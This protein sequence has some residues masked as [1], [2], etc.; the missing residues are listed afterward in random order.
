MK[1]VDSAAKRLADGSPFGPSPHR[2]QDAVGY[3]AA[4]ANPCSLL[5]GEFDQPSAA[6]NRYSCVPAVEGARLKIRIA[7]DTLGGDAEPLVLVRGALDWVK[8]YGERT[9]PGMGLVF[10]GEAQRIAP[11]LRGTA[12]E[13]VD[14]P[15]CLAVD[16]PLRA[17]LH[18]TIAS[19]MRSAIGALADGSV[20]AVVS[21]G[22]TGALMALSRHLLGMLPGVRRP[23]IIKKLAGERGE[24]RMLDLGANVGTDAAQLHQFARMGHVAAA[25][26]E[27]AAPTVGLLNIGSEVSKGPLE[28]RTAG[29]LLDADDGLRYIGFVEP[30]RLFT[31]AADIVVAD[32]FAGNIAL[33]SAEGAARMARFL[34]TRELAGASPS[35]AVAKALLGARLKRVRDAY[36]PQLY[37][38]AVLLGLS[39]VVV[40]SHGSADQ[41]GFRSAVAQAAGALK[42][43]LVPKLGAGI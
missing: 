4:A 17:T 14:A 31:T 1:P 34:L 33:K 22:S 43:Q 42:A 19:S 32:G 11:L 15:R 3:A 28:V 5:G 7:I 26:D 20:D 12:H 13:L 41:E 16:D 38:G 30:D 23:A 6:L 24:F 27:V 36:N 35:L 39:G 40:K 21:S 8:H 37:N 29:R 2:P 9:D 10:F 25:V 18:G